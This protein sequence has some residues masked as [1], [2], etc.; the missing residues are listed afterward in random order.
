MQNSF[1]SERF[2]TWT[3]FET[4]TQKNSEMAYSVPNRKRGL[5]LEAVYNLRNDFPESYFSIGL[6][7]KFVDFFGQMV[8]LPDS[9]LQFSCLARIAGPDCA[10]FCWQMFCSVGGS[11]I[12][13]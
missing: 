11:E 13:N 12:H 8:I 7:M 9:G 4:E 1:S 5:L 6:K 2:R 10:W 3:R